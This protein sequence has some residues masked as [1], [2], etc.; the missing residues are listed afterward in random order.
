MSRRLETQAAPG[1]GN[2]CQAGVSGRLFALDP[3]VSFEFCAISLGTL[4][5]KMK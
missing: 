1:E 4:V 2:R 3:M 5:N